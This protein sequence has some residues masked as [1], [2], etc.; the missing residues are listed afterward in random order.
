MLLIKHLIHLGDVCE[1]KL[2]RNGEAFSNPPSLTREG[3]TKANV[4][5]VGL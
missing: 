5:A 2:V 1:S 4:W 3:Q